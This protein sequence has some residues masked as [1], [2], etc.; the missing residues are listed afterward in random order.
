M[1]PRFPQTSVLLQGRI[2]RVHSTREGHLVLRL[3]TDEGE[4]ELRGTA[5][6]PVFDDESPVPL[7]DLRSRV[8]SEALIA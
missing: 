7:V 2:I 5:G 3:R 6:L 4:I 1:T 8:G